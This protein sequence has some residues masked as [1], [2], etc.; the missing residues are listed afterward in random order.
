MENW[1]CKKSETDITLSTLPGKAVFSSALP[2]LHFARLQIWLQ[3][4]LMH[5]CYKIEACDD[6]NPSHTLTKLLEFIYSA[7]VLLDGD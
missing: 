5:T 2:I 4:H 3:I 1:L 7:A 6:S